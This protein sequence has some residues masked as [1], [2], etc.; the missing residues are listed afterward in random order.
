MDAAI[1]IDRID[2]SIGSKTILR[3]VSLDFA[4]DQVNV[5]VGPNG[6]GKSTLLKIAA[7][8]VRP[9][10]GTIRYDGFDIAKLTL[11]ELA[12]R[13]AFLTQQAEVGFA[14]S[15]ETVVMMGRYPFF[16]R[17][18]SGLDQRIVEDS[19]EQVGMSALRKRI[20][21]TLS[22]GEQ[23]RVHVARVLAQV[24]SGEVNAGPKLLF[25]DEP[26]SALDIRHQL[27]LLS[28]IRALTAQ[29]CTIVMTVHD[30]NTAFH[31]ADR[32]TFLRD[33]MLIDIIDKPDTIEPALIQSVFDV[34]AIVLAEPSGFRALHLHL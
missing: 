11:G 10:H 25:L 34:K 22:G 27:Q 4:R 5:L 18:P 30:L 14:L 12:R 32:L 1:S 31:H 26:L 19:L 16:Q 21:T 7:G 20:F 23:K 17:T 29:H 6:A 9:D 33:G 28:V 24:G 2:Y 8:R 3:G 15:V 13:R